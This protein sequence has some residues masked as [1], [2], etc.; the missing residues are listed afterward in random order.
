MRVRGRSDAAWNSAL[1]FL[2]RCK[3]QSRF[4][5]DI[6]GKVALLESDI[7]NKGH[8]HLSVGMIHTTDKKKSKSQ[9]M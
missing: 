4:T 8:R 1:A 2:K 3:G 6:K 7:R 9:K 5:S